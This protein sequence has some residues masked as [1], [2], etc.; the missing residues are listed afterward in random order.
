MVVVVVQ[1]QCQ[2]LAAC[3]RHLLAS[4]TP[5]N[6]CLGE[7]IVQR[8]GHKGKNCGINKHLENLLK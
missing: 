6:P 1:G 2:I 7:K 5:G 3:N 8:M 4:V